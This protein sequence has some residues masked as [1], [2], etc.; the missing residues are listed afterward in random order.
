M[1]KQNR[2]FLGKTIATL[3]WLLG[4]YCL[5][6]APWPTFAGVVL[7]I[8]GRGMMEDVRKLEGRGRVKRQKGIGKKRKVNFGK[9]V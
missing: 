9:D 5:S 3:I 1:T 7:F 6:K 4:L 2:V 8:A